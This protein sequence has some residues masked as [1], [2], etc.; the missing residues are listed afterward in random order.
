MEKT[1]E[2]A[3]NRFYF[4][5]NGDDDTGNDNQLTF[6]CQVSLTGKAFYR[7]LTCVHA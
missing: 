1:S 3:L 4:K 7:K 2:F 5:F 6:N